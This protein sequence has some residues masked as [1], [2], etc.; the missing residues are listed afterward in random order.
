[1]PIETFA[2]EQEGFD[3]LTLPK[4]GMPCR[5]LPNKVPDSV[6]GR[7]AIISFHHHLPKFTEL[8]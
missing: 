3:L 5:G 4:N 7:S 8:N 1:L 6:A 2:L